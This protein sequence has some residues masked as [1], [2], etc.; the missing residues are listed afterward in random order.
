ML[1]RCLPFAEDAVGPGLMGLSRFQR[2]LVSCCFY[3]CASVS[4]SCGVLESGLKSRRLL[5]QVDIAHRHRRG[6][7]L[8]VLG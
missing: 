5:V 7:V 1:N 4:F 3:F 2:Y 6:Q 8:I